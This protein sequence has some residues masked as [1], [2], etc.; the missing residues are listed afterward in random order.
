MS[1]CPVSRIRHVLWT[2]FE[3]M[4]FHVAMKGVHFEYAVLFTIDSFGV[5]AAGNVFHC[6]VPDS[7]HQDEA[8]IGTDKVLESTL[9]NGA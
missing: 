4:G 8:A 6:L 9:R 1:P 7:P 5:L 2:Y 3:L